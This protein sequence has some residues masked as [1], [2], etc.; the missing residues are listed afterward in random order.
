MQNGCAID[1]NPLYNPY[2]SNNYISPLS[3]SSYSDRTVN[4]PYKISENDELYKIF[5]RHGWSWGGK[6]NE[7]KDYQHFEKR[8]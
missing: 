6:W 4:N 3:G 8:V 2:V 7:K 1:I 5:K